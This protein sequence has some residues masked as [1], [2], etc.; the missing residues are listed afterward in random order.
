MTIKSGPALSGGVAV[1]DIKAVDDTG[2]VEGYASIFG[3]R[4]LGGDVVMPGAFK[5]CLTRRGARGIKMLYQHDPYRPIGVWTDLAE[6]A[7][8]LRA[9][10]RVLIGTPDGA[11]S[12][13]LLKE[14]ALDGLSIGYRS[15]RDRWDKGK[16][17][18]LLEEVD[19]REISLVTFPMNE[20][21]TVDTVK[22]H[23]FDP[24]T[25]ERAFRDEGLSNREAKAAT[26][27][28]RKLIRRDGGFPKPDRR[29]A[30]FDALMDSIARATAAMRTR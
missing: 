9:K 10:G 23:D 25:W 12:F 15:I 21:A 24:Q 19:L 29:D 1:F 14:G 28:A 7:R 5:A 22:A 11:S 20:R 30:G 6:D 26:A 13:T 2:T 18:R 8:G 4:D 17:A 27:A 16:D 3:E